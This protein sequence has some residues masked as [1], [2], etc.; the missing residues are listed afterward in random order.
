M[1][2]SCGNKEVNKI[3][4]ETM[5]IADSTIVNSRNHIMESD[6]IQRASDSVTQ[7]KVVKVIKDI[8]HLTTTV[9][10]LKIEKSLLSKELKVSKQNVRIDTVFIETKKSFWGKEKKTIKT[11]SDSQDIETI[12]ST[13]TISDTIK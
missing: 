3:K 10:K 11:K 13:T 6:T 2:V 1:L 9:E 4:N 5:V 7:E 8:Q 12:D